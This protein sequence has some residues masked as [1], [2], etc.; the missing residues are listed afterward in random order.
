MSETIKA[1]RGRPR[2]T[3]LD[4]NDAK[5]RAKLYAKNK[6]KE[7][8]RCEV[9]NCDVG[10]YNLYHEKSNKHMLNIFKISSINELIRLKEQEE[11]KKEVENDLG[12]HNCL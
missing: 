7:C 10:Y 1:I 9:C 4:V 5:E 8:K 6:N 12:W 2:T 11:K 3:N